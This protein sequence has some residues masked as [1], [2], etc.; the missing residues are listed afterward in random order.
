MFSHSQSTKFLT[1]STR[2]EKKLK[3]K[4]KL[5]IKNNSDEE[6]EQYENKSEEEYETYNNQ[7]STEDRT[8]R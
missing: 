8:D 1:F 3:I 2:Y 5:S 4:F 6:Y 7:N